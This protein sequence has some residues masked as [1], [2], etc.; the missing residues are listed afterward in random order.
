MA[1]RS[2]Q[3]KAIIKK[4]ESI[5]DEDL[6]KLNTYLNELEINK[7]VT[8]KSFN[9]RSKRLKAQDFSFNEARKLTKNLNSSL[10][11]EV[12]E[13]RAIEQ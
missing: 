13:E 8:D 2:K 10:A 4:I 3:I 1:I 5:S 7:D 11:D 9:K 6:K 12:I